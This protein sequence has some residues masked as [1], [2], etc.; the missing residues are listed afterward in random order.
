MGYTFQKS[1]SVF[2]F[3]LGEAF[4]IICIYC[5]KEFYFTHEK[6]QIYSFEILLLLFHLY[7]MHYVK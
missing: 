4:W 3:S 1:A 7:F 5:A 2:K 6:I